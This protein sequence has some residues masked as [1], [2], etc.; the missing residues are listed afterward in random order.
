MHS[1]IDA[2]NCVQLFGNV[3]FFGTMMMSRSRRRPDG[4]V[5]VGELSDAMM[6]WHRDRGTWD[7]RYL[8]TPIINRVTSKT[9]P[10]APSL[11]CKC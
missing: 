6:Q 11:V 5:T 10:Q 9:A 3:A 4:S 7:L 1:I 8:I 2:V